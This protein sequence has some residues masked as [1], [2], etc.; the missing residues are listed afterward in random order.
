MNSDLTSNDSI[1]CYPTIRGIFWTIL[2]LAF[3]GLLTY[4]V[5]RDYIV[6]FKFDI[7]LLMQLPFVFGFLLTV[8][9]LF[10]IKI[11]E[12][13]NKKLVIKYP[14]LFK[15]KEIALDT[16][17]KAYTLRHKIRSTFAT[18]GYET[19]Y[20]GKRLVLELN[21]NKKIEITQFRTG[22]FEALLPVFI[23]E[24]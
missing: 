15:R 2:G 13:K 19:L 11:I 22:N 3:F 17:I 10:T 21:S 16:I 9:Y 12:V 4:V 5:F 18:W 14:L 8:Y 6:K 23:K 7:L 24:K 1:I 20:E